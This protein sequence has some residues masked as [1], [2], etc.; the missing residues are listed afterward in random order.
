MAN[1][2]EMPSDLGFLV[3]DDSATFRDAIN[4][5]LKTLGYKKIFM[6]CDEV[7]ALELLRRETVGFI[8]C[9]RFLRQMSGMDLLKEIRET[10]EFSRVP[11]MMMA[12]DIPKEDVFLASEFGIDGYLK[13]PFVLK[14]VSARISASM[15]RFQNA[16][17]PEGLFDEV[18]ESFL[19]G[20]YKESIAHYEKL[21][22]SMPNSARVRVGI[23][24]AYRAQEN[25]VEAEK[26]LREGVKSN[27]MYVH[28]QHD[29]GLVYLQ[30]Q[31]MDEA[32]KC[33]DEANKL[34]PSN[35][36]RYE[37]LGDILM[38]ASRFK[39]A[40]DYLMKATKLELVYPPLFSQLG[41]ALFSQKKLEKASKVFEKALQQQPDNTSF[42]NSMGI[43]MKDMGKYQESI[44]Y[45]NQ[46]LKYRPQDTKI[47]YN[48]VL[49]YII[50]KEWDRARKGC[51]LILKF[52]PTSEKAVTKL[53]EIDK[54]EGKLPAAA[55]TGTGNPSAA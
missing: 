5:T 35:P 10:P 46:A 51:L 33:F 39:E 13:K 47:I 32:L 1:F 21:L 38:R 43:C 6:V 22:A 18:R 11:F 52:D 50:M 25:L 27:P 3:L 54:L 14:D 24:S 19:K 53:K 8:I 7:T 20:K 23:A 2:I 16:S 9:E 4:T 40:E 42:L 30:L 31:K 29:L 45:Y 44:N 28:A 36:V 34:S 12:S 49:C 48:K 55:N 17:N 41:K 15:A 37:I 26:H